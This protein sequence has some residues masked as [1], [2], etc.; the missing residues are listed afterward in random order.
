MKAS[1]SVIRLKGVEDSGPGPK[2]G[3][4]SCCF[5][6][7]WEALGTQPWNV[8]QTRTQRGGEQIFPGSPGSSVLAQTFHTVLFM[9]G[10]LLRTAY[11]A[12]S[13]ETLLFPTDCQ[14]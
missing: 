7:G 14:S 10:Y 5:S 3:M 8:T 4:A 2:T 9:C 6:Q 13:P 12:R 11:G 1:G